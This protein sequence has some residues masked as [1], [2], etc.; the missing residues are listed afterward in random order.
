MILG[1]SGKIKSG[2]DTVGQMI[3]DLTKKKHVDYVTDDHGMHGFEDVSYI[4][5]FKIRK[6]ADKLKQ[7]A[8]LLTG[9]PRDK[10]EDQDFKASLMDSEWAQPSYKKQYPEPYIPT[11]RE[12]LQRLG[13]E[14]MR[15]TLHDNV[16][17]NSAMSDIDDKNIIFTDVRFPNEAQAVTDRDGILI[18]INRYPP[19]CSP[20][21]MNEHAT[22][23]AL[24]DWKFDHI[25]Y[26]LGTLDDLKFQ[27]KEV[28]KHIH[29]KTK[30]TVIEVARG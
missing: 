12:F 2:K 7:V 9:I 15:N 11:Y 30:S 24:D 4:P 10:F 28:L 5:T 13:T 1:L 29:S 18:R 17:V 8:S 19:G 25:I 3:I 23:K 26:N 16:W 6:F 27:I 20:I 22:E 14:T 21:L